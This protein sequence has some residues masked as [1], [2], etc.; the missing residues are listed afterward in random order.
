MKVQLYILIILFHDACMNKHSVNA[1]VVFGCVRRSTSNDLSIISTGSKP[2]RSLFFSAAA[3]LL[4]LMSLWVFNCS[5]QKPDEYLGCINSCK[6]IQNIFNIIWRQHNILHIMCTSFQKLLQSHYTCT[7]KVN[8]WQRNIGLNKKIA[9]VALGL[10]S[11]TL[12]G[13]VFFLPE[14][15]ECLFLGEVQSHF[16]NR[17]W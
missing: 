5:I 10:M 6:Q 1:Y 13:A 4:S 15:E 11:A 3:D 17:D 7:L 2:L 16:P 8:F 9:N 14:T 12:S